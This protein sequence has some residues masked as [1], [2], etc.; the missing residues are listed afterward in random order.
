MLVFLKEMNRPCRVYELDVL[1]TSFRD[2]LCKESVVGR[3]S[4]NKSLVV[5]LRLILSGADD[6]ATQEDA[7]P[8]GGLVRIS[9]VSYLNGT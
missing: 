2:P 8:G 4:A 7:R 1:V 9:P 3:R 5:P 6:V